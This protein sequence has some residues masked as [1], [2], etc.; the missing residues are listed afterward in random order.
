MDV[1]HKTRS[2]AERI[3]VCPRPLF[4]RE[5]TILDVED[6]VGEFEESRVVCHDQDGPAVIS[7]DAGED[8][9]DGVAS[10]AGWRSPGSRKMRP[11][12]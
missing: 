11:S 6:A 5:R 4:V 7:G 8:G 2:G 10:S 9:H 12:G 1:R 3:H